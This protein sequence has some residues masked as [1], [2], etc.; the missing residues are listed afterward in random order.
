M[1]VDRRA[2]TPLQ[3]KGMTPLDPKAGAR[4]GKGKDAVLACGWIQMNKWR[5]QKVLLGFRETPIKRLLSCNT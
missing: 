1:E 3:G 2:I 5:G 4:K